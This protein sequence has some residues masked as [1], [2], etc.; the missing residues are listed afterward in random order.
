MSCDLFFIGADRVAEGLI[1]IWIYIHTA[2][3]EV[4]DMTQFTGRHIFYIL[5]LLSASWF[6]VLIFQLGKHVSKYSTVPAWEQNNKLRSPHH[7]NTGTAGASR[8]YPLHWMMT[9]PMLSLKTNVARYSRKTFVYSMPTSVI[10]L[11]YFNPY[12]CLFIAQPKNRSHNIACCF[13]FFREL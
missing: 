8:D 11:C 10:L 12:I 1:R 3:I 7:K 2:D 5:V 6:L 13:I 4:A 9:R